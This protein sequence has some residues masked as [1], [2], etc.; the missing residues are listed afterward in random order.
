MIV[1]GLSCVSSSNP[2]VSRSFSDVIAPETDGG[3]RT[4]TAGELHGDQHQK[5]LPTL[6]AAQDFGLRSPAEMSA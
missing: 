2:S 1:V 5:H 3:S 6:S 4:I